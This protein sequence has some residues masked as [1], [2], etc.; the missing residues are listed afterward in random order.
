MPL[1]AGDAEK[2]DL[3]IEQILEEKKI[4]DLSLRFEKLGSKESD[5]GWSF[6]GIVA[7]ARFIRVLFL[8]P[9]IDLIA[10]LN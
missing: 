7:N 1:D 10:L 4:Y 5:R 3:T 2:G 6:P 8:I 9:L